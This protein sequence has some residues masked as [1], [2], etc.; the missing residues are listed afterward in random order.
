MRRPGRRH[1]NPQP[2][3]KALETDTS[4][5]HHGWELAYIVPIALILLMVIKRLTKGKQHPPHIPLTLSTKVFVA[6]CALQEDAMAGKVVAVTGTSSGVGYFVA[7]AAAQHNAAKVFLLN[8]PSAR[9]D[10]AAESIAAVAGPD[11]SVI[12]VPCDLCDFSSVTAAAET[13]LAKT[14]KSGLNGLCLNAGIMMAPDVR[15]KDRYD[16][17]MQTNHHAHVL[18]ASLLMP[19][20]EK[21]TGRV[22]CTGSMSQYIS[23]PPTGSKPLGD[24]DARF[25]EPSEAGS[26]GGNAMP[27]A[28]ERYHQT[29][30]GQVCFG[31]ALA[32]K[33]TERKSGASAVC[34]DP[35]WAETN[36][37]S[38]T[39]KCHSTNGSS[40]DTCLISL[41]WAF[42]FRAMNATPPG[43]PGGACHSGPDAAA[44]VLRAIFGTDVGNGDFIAPLYKSMAQRN[45]W[46]PPIKT[47]E[48]GKG[49]DGAGADHSKSLIEKQVNRDTAWEASTAMLKNVAGS[50]NFFVKCKRK[51]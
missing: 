38:N 20:L 15:T 33:L 42:F 8:R 7:A 17:Q 28:E 12:S 46:G 2:V 29:K 34:V 16:I 47:F 9:A 1:N 27:S 51:R 10:A 23:F 45:G 3:E 22:T 26:L 4:L 11:C 49:I 14:S 32:E 48:A 44:S 43:L 5:T 36:L 35:G 50:A 41:P 18:L 30:L 40:L 31:M 19:M 24:L 39:L 21:G 25:F 6:E 37:T 13:I